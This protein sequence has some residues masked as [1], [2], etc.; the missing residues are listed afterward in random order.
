M[1][2]ET[3][4]KHL[5]GCNKETL[6][7]YLDSAWE[8]LSEKKQRLLFGDLYKK[9]TASDLDAEEF[10]EE[11]ELFYEQSI[12]GNYYAP[13][14]INSKNFMHVPA[15]TEN[16]FDKIGDLLD[17]ACELVDKGE[18]E[19]VLPAFKLLMDLIRRMENGEEIIFADEYGSWMISAKRDYEKVYQTLIES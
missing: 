14:N 4:F 16:W 12:A 11:V 6:I 5:S 3:I 18:K 1:E 8:H 2:K 10:F 7:N 9:L 13:F 19:A 17:N 15:E